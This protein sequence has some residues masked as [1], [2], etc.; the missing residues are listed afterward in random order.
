MNPETLLAE[1]LFAVAK[2]IADFADGHTE[3]LDFAAYSDL[4]YYDTKLCAYAR[5]IDEVQQF[6]F[7]EEEIAEAL[8]HLEYIAER[9]ALPLAVGGDHER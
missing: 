3:Q 7:L 5:L 6:A 2:L 8:D 9:F 4:S 1:R